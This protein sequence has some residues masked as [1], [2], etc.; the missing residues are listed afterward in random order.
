MSALTM[1]AMLH[2]YLVTHDLR[3]PDFI[4]RMG[5]F[6]SAASKVWPPE[7][8]DYGI[9]LQ[10]PDFVTAF[11]GT[12]NVHQTSDTEHAIDVACTLA[13]AAY[14]APS[15]DHLDRAPFRATALELY[16]TFSEGVRQF[17]FPDNPLIGRQAYRVPPPRKYNWQYHHTGV[18]GR[19]MDATLPD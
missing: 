7:E 3:I 18:F 12:T 1:D 8:N 5:R 2:A 11:D 13:W 14:F 19:L 4:V 15:R 17:T 6:E 9:E 16:A 10:M